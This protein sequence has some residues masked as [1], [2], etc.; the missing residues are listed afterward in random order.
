VVRALGRQLVRVSRSWVRFAV[1]GSTLGLTACAYQLSGLEPGSDADTGTAA[2]TRDTDTPST[3]TSEPTGGASSLSSGDG[4]STDVTTETPSP[5]DNQQ[6]DEGETAIDCGGDDCQPCGFGLPCLDDDDCESG[7][8]NETC[9]AMGCQNGEQDGTETD[10]DCGGDCEP[11]PDDAQCA[12]EAD[13]Q[14]GVCEGETCQVPT[15]T[16]GVKN[17]AEADEDCGTEECGL[18]P[19]GASCQEDGQCVQGTCKDLICADPQCTDLRTNGDET[20]M[21]CGGSCPPCAAD[22]ICLDADDC[23]S[24]VCLQ[25][26]ATTKRCAEATCEDEV[27]N[28]GETDIDCGGTGCETCPDGARCVMASDCQS[29]VCDSVSV[30][31]SEPACTDDVRNGDEVGI[32]CGGACPGCPDGTPCGGDAECASGS[33]VDEVCVAPTC[34]DGRLNQDE[35][36]VDCGGSC[37]GCG[38]GLECQGDADCLSN[39]C[40]QTCQPGGVNAACA[41]GTDCFSGLCTDDQCAPGYRGAGCGSDAD[42]QSGYCKSDDTCGSGDLG[43][44]CE[45]ASDCASNLCTNSVCA[46]SRFVVRTDGGTD[47]AVV[48]HRTQFQANASDP[49]RAWQDVALVY[50]FSVVAPETHVNYQSRYYQGPNLTTKDSR[51][52]AFNPAGTDWMLVWRAVPGNT[53]A[54]PTGSLT[55]IELQ[56]RDNPWSAFNFGNDYSYRTGGYADNAKVVVCQR[57]DGRWVHTQGTPPTSIPEPCA[58]V[59]DTCEG[60]AVTCDVLER[61]D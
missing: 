55:A 23:E 20:D 22:A 37:D 53:T 45:Q 29:S 54:V 25:T 41:A 5:C 35:S 36:D 6:L 50:F 13:C 46:A 52:L 30:T 51:F 57:V 14:S 60:S 47:A 38:F 17:G 31:C 27:Q 16:D 19:D 34:D 39:D 61:A 1:V 48:N 28:G 59:V 26:S 33:C 56:L 49:S 4:S 7:V 24:R 18:C 40:N 42:C 9:L 21:D 2:E 11:C 10:R 15:C 44:A 3:E 43:A 58:L 32:D 12:V 8:C